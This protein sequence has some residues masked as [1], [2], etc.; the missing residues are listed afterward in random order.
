MCL[1]D[2]DPLSLEISVSCFVGLTDASMCKSKPKVPSVVQGRSGGILWS[3]CSAPHTEPGGD[4]LPTTM[5]SMSGMEVRDLPPPPL[6]RCFT[7]Y[8]GQRQTT[9]E[10]VWG[11]RSFQSC[12][13]RSSR[14]SLGPCENR[15]G[16]FLRATCALMGPDIRAHRNSSGRQSPGKVL[17]CL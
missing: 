6:V 5:H 12:G 7:T 10:K 2:P 17:H 1:R 14:A 9:E 13:A 8:A 3:C 4:F 11:P 15:S 16:L